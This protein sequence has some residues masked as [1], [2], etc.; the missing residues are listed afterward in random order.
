[1]GEDRL[2]MAERPEQQ[3]VLGG[4]GQ[5]VLAADDV[6]DLHRGVIDDDREVVERGAIR[7][8]DDE[9]ATQ[10]RRVDLDVPPDQ[11]VERHDAFADPEPQRE[12]PPLRL[13]GRSLV[14][15]QPGAPADVVGRLPGRFLRL[16][17]RVELLGRAV[18]RVGQVTL[19]KLRRRGRIRVEPLHLAVRR[20]G[21]AGP[22]AGDLR[23]LVPGDPEPMQVVEDVLLVGDR[24]PGDVGVLETQDERAAGP[25][26]EQEVEQRRPPRADV[27]RAGWTRRDPDAGCGHRTIL[28]ACPLGAVSE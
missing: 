21:P 4:V 10:R 22:F 28:G 24:R 25:P 3:D 9:V 18:A 8:D 5:V 12:A 1:M 14:G 20:V 16:A 7:P 11:V 15:R 6:A 13:A 17:V 23:T 27:Q 26:G 19:S 2:R